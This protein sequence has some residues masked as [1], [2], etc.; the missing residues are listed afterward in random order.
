MSS[1]RHP[2]PMT[3]PRP[4]PSRLLIIPVALSPSARDHGWSRIAEA[5]APFDAHAGVEADSAAERRDHAQPVAP[6]ADRLRGRRGPHR[7][8]G[9]HPEPMRME[10]ERGPLVPRVL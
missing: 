1:Q 6:L 2:A 9:L 7:V 4:R 10:A 3:S 8:A 5:P